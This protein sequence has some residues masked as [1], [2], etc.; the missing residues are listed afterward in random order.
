LGLPA[1]KYSP[2]HTY[3][4]SPE[5]ATIRAYEARRAAANMTVAD[6]AQDVVEHVK[7]AVRQTVKKVKPIEKA[8]AWLADQLALEPA[9]AVDIERRA[10]GAKINARTLR[11]AR[12]RLGVKARRRGGG[13]W[14]TLPS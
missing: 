6:L 8:M 13:W 7:E 2:V 11:R 1:E 10:K 3:G 4:V 9:S 5:I 12:E 14:W